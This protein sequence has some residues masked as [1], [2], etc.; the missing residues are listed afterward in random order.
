MFNRSGRT[1]SVE[2]VHSWAGNLFIQGMEKQNLFVESLRYLISS[3]ETRATKFD[4][5]F[6]DCRLWLWVGYIKKDFTFLI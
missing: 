6:S 2:T 4:A 5:Q 3:T 1:F